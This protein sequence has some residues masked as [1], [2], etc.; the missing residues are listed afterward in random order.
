MSQP[1]SQLLRETL[2]HQPPLRRLVLY[3]SGS[4]LRVILAPK[5]HLLKS[6]DIFDYHNWGGGC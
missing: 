6:E 5:E 1:K 2:T 4:Q 3:P